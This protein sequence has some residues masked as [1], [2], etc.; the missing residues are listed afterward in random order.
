MRRICKAILFAILAFCGPAK[1]EEKL[2]YAVVYKASDYTAIRT[3]IF[4]MDP[5]T[6]DRKLVFSDDKA[7]IILSQQLYN[8]D[9][10][11][12][13]GNKIL[14][15]ACQRGTGG[16]PLGSTRGLYELSTDGKN[17]FRKIAA[18]SDDGPFKGAFIN[19]EGTL[20]GSLY[21]Q[22]M[23]QYLFIN[24]AKSGKLVNKICVDSIFLD[25]YASSIGWVPDG[26]GIYFTLEVGDADMTS[27]ES[28]KITGSYIMDLTSGN[29]TKLPREDSLEKIGIA[30]RLMGFMPNGDMIFY[31]YKDLFIMRAGKDAQLDSISF[32]AVNSMPAYWA[33]IRIS[34][35]GKNIAA[36]KKM[37][38]A[39]ETT[40]GIWIKDLEKGSERMLFSLPSDQFN[41]PFLGLVGWLSE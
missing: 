14:A 33:D 12:L 29:M 8:F 3:D 16:N 19:R 18:Q 5:K 11:L 10:P 4:S 24:D 36:A 31:R 40:N 15:H 2:V 34:P 39:G 25:C 22:K 20:I 13:G 30:T 38:S 32:S 28:Y 6:G 21:W 37:L 41:G 35:S 9:Y 23:H 26:K 1:A 27:D 7:A 17:S